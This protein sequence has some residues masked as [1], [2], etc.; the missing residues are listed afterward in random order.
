MELILTIVV[1]A[2]YL[3]LRRTPQRKGRIGEKIVARALAKHLDPTVYKT[4]N[5]VIIPDQS[6]GTTQI[7]HVVFSM[8]GIF[9]VETKNMRGW[10]YGDEKSPQWTQVIYRYRH[11]FQNPFRQNY[12]HIKCLAGLLGIDDS[13]LNHAIVFIGDCRIN[14]DL[15]IPPSLVKN[16]QELAAYIETFKK[17]VFSAPEIRELVNRLSRV[18]LTPSHNLE[19]AHIAHVNRT[20]NTKNP[21]QCFVPLPCLSPTLDSNDD[22]PA[23]PWCGSP[24]VLR[25]AKQGPNVGNTFWGCPKYPECRGI[26]NKS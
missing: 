22:V 1:V 18:M 4:V 14:N 11:Q 21:Y 16:G 15:T 23:C 8:L 10:I 26:R 17:P 13:L 19:R 25:C 6:G 7:D 2:F 24:M 12:K 5:D 3:A 9:V 20:V